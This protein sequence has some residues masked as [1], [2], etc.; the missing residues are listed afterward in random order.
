MEGS[1]FKRMLPGS[2]AHGLNHWAI[3]LRQHYGIS[4]R[5]DLIFVK[6]SAPGPYCLD[7]TI[8][9]GVEKV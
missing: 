4:T 5:I 7:D 9:G 1:R 2:R 3:L 6:D 8:G